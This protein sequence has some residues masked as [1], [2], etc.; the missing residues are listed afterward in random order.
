MSIRLGIDVGG[1]FMDLVGLLDG[2]VRLAKVPSTPDDPVAAIESGLEVM[3]WTL[4]EVSEVALGTTLATN[5]V[6]EKKGGVTALLCTE[7]FRD[8]LEQQ[9]WR[10]RHLFDLQ[11]VKPEPLAPRSLR[12]GVPERVAA[13]GEVLREVDEAGVVALAETLRERGVESVAICFLNAHQNGENE[14]RA[15]EILERSGGPRYLSISSEVA[16]LIGEWERTSTTLLN[17]YVHPVVKRYLDQVSN[18]LA[19]SG[20]AQLSVM[21]SN[22]GVVS[23]AQASEEPVRTI[24]SGPAAGVSSSVSLTDA[25]GV[26]DAITLDMG[27]TSTDVAVIQDGGAEV[28]KEGRIEYN[29]P[30]T[31][32]MLRIET[33]GAGGGSIAWID[34]GG[35]LKVG[36]RSAG[37]YP[38]P[39]CY[40]R[41]GTEPTITDAQL[42]L[43]RLP[44]DGLL[45]GRMDVSVDL[46]MEALTSVAEPL[47]LSAEE[48]AAGIIKIANT[49]M[50]AAV[51]AV[52]V[53]RGIDPRSFALIPFG[54]AGPLHACEIAEELGLEEV[55][56]PV[57]PGVFSA[58]GLV[59][60][61]TRV[62]KVG[63]LNRVADAG[64]AEH[65]SG[66][67]DR[68]E[69]ECHAV[70]DT[71]GIDQDVRRTVRSID[72]R[73][74]AQSYTVPIPCPAG[75]LTAADVEELVAS[76]HEQHQRLYKFSMADQVPVFASAEVTIT[77][78]TPPAAIER[79]GAKESESRM[80]AGA[81]T[82]RV[83]LL[84]SDSWAE[85]PAYR[86][87]EL[88]EGTVIEGPAVIDQAD[89]T[90][91]VEAGFRGTFD[92]AG[93]LFLR[94]DIP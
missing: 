34:E 89:S 23:A 62:T 16:P 22:G 75:G 44:V 38:G 84:A 80:D 65:L 94:K 74:A 17:A 29:V 7:G 53:D 37:A 1:T 78:G 8:I 77:D 49:K 10:R 57:T 11:Q 9:R 73:Y 76:F 42:V 6:L 90:V 66:E 4:A 20:S 40:S 64:I 51:R 15:R 35:S 18:D 68:L 14:R 13:S 79:Y 25:V 83:F 85:V 30:V 59:S 31:V 63:S 86:R 87:T 46:A 24:L 3:G 5:T 81:R 82:R 60:A 26:R 58:V 28:T 39:A 27:G 45:G 54:G 71:H 55:V 43:G 61:A 47:G 67:F 92:K 32:P 88:V 48:L 41:G 70:L 50:A 72:A 36:P 56:V 12:L 33:I 21:Q 93:N 19:T 2:E 91:L 52:T 69:G